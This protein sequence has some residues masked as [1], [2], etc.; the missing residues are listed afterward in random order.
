MVDPPQDLQGSP[1]FL[2]T[3]TFWRC[4]GLGLYIMLMAVKMEGALLVCRTVGLW[5]DIDL[6][7]S[8]SV[9][10]DSGI[11][12][13]QRRLSHMAAGRSCSLMVRLP[14][15]PSSWLEPFLFRNDSHVRHDSSRPAK[16]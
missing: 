7:F 10:R 4:S 9:R 13:E 14:S 8:D 1:V 12:S 15:R 6:L 16:V 5:R 11:A 2:Y 3:R